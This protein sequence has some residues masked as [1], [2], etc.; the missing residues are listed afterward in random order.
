MTKEDVKKKAV[1]A[2]A[3]VKN[4]A[5]PED[6]SIDTASIQMIERSREQGIETPAFS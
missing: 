4:V 6:I 2:K 5:K 3:K 1:A